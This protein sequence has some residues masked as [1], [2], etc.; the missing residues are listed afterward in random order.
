MNGYPETKTVTVPAGQTRNQF[1]TGSRFALT[2]MTQPC[3]VSFD[4][5]PFFTLP[6]GY[7]TELPPGQFFRQITFTNPGGTDANLTFNHSLE[8]SFAAL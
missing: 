6:V 7:K 2:A 1:I 5:G 3:Q 8:A 4:G